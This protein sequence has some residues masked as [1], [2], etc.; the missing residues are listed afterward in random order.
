M[1]KLIELLVKVSDLLK[2][3]IGD[4]FDLVED[5]SE[6]A[7]KAVNEL[8]DVVEKNDDIFDWV[9][10]KVGDKKGDE[11]YDVIKNVLPKVA[12]QIGIIEGFVSKQT[13]PQAATVA[14]LQNLKEKQKEGRV[15]D[16]IYLSA[17]LLVAIVNKKLPLDIA[18]LATQKAFRSLFGKKI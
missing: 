15:K 2:N 10:N 16:W 14:L 1:K 11:V 17:S 8:K 5:K 7:V 6:I 3:F 9:F 4:L 12:L 13:S 18:V